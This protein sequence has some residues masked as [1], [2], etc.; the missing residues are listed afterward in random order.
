MKDLIHK[1]IQTD[2]GG[3]G[4]NLGRGG[5]QAGSDGGAKFR[6]VLHGQ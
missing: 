4:R 6:R 5:G 2:K 1:A 3:Q